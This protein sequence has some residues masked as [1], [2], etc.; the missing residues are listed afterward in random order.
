MCD[1]V[2]GAIWEMRNEILSNYNLHFNPIQFIQF[3]YSP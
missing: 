2:S 3:I 1:F